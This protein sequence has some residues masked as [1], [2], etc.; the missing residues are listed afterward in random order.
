MENVVAARR[1]RKSM[2]KD[3]DKEQIC[4]IGYLGKNSLD[5]NILNQYAHVKEEKEGTNQG[6]RQVGI[7]FKFK[8]KMLIKIFVTCLLL[9]LCLVIKLTCKEKALENKYVQILKREYNKDYSKIYA[10]EKIEDL[11]YCAY[12]NLGKYIIPDS[13]K[14][15]IVS[16]YVNKVKPYIVNFDLREMLLNEKVINESASISDYSTEEVAT[17]YNGSIGEEPIE[18]NA[19]F[20]E[21]SAVSMMHDDVSEILS[22]NINFIKPINGTITSIY[23]ARDE[24]FDGVNSYHTGLDI[25]AKAGTK[26]KSVC[27]GT[28]IKVKKMDKYYGNY[29]VVEFNGVRIKY[30]HMLEIKV[31]LNDKIKQGDIIGAVGSTGMSTG[32]H[33]HIEI[34]I[35][36]RTVDPQ[37]IIQF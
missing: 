23:G 6:E 37:S 19:Y 20:E 32:P 13:F 30:A 17:V 1:L 31:N 21:S 8:T 26:I 11:S 33:L 24:I 3:M 14:E 29:A 7:K 2:L 22:K 15:S 9:F 10:L 18:T 27:D 28:V 35:N 25:A 16:K 36:S 4:D 34:S 12:D 5:A